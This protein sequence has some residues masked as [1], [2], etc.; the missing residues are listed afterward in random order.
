MIISFSGIDGCGKS[1]YIKAI[2]SNQ[3][4]RVNILWTRVGYTPGMDRMKAVARKIMGKKLP[5][6][7]RS[8]QR[9]N[10]LKKPLIQRVWITLA[11]LEL[12]WIFIFKI[13]FL[14]IN[15]I[16]LLDRQ[17]QDSIIDLKVLFGSEVVD[18][19]LYKLMIKVILILMPKVHSIGIIIDYKTSIFR[20]ANK[21]EPFPDTDEEKL[22]R[23]DFYTSVLNSKHFDIILDGNQDV[24]LN[25]I[26]L[27]ELINLG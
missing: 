17:F 13:R 8:T 15:S 22:R 25:L 6:P 11:L 14:S 23:I 19:Y 9:T 7:G 5:K 20:C 24:E 12:M 18:D 4:R 16:L 1:T 10:A 3:P 26:K 27:E 2:T 21:F